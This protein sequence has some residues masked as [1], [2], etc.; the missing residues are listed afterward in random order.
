[1]VQQRDWGAACCVCEEAPGALLELRLDV[2]DRQE[3][4][5]QS[6]SPNSEQGMR[7]DKLSRG[8][9]SFVVGAAAQGYGT[10]VRPEHSDGALWA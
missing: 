5:K 9:W 2:D 1:M 6:R 8:W 4:G 3:T 10:R 7:Q